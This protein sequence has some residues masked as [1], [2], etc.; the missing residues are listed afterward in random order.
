MP[1]VNDANETLGDINYVIVDA[2]GQ[3]TTIAVGVG[4]F[5]GIG[6]KNVGVAYSSL[7]LNSDANN[8]RVQ[9]RKSVAIRRRGDSQMP[10]Q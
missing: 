1:V 3:I 5:L 8:R 6:E 10:L 9:R 4:G 7:N 2:K